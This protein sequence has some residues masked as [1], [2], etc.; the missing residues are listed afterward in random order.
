MIVIDKG[1]VAE[2]GNHDQLI[3]AEGIYK[4]LVLRQLEAGEMN[5]D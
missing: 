5:A 4:K 3:A 1:K 2:Q